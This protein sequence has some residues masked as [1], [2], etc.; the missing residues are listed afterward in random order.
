[1]DDAKNKSDLKVS[2]LSRKT[3]I[4]IVGVI[5]G[6]IGGYVYYRRIGCSGGAC[7]L[8]SNPYLSMIWGGVIGYLIADLFVK[9]KKKQ[10]IE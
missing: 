10:N 4:L 6:I 7:P 9:H 3:V 5:T 8:T 2:F 1:M